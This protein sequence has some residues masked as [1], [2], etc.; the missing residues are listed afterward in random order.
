MISNRFKA[1]TQM[2][3]DQLVESLKRQDLSQNEMAEILA[4]FSHHDEIRQIS[5]EPYM[6]H[7][8]Y[9]RDGDKHYSDIRYS[10]NQRIL[11]L[12]HDTIES[13]KQDALT[14]AD[15]RYLKFDNEIVT[16]LDSITK[17]EGERYL[18][19]I[20]RLSRNEFVRPV[21]IVD[22]RH[23]MKNG[24]SPNRALLYRL[25]LPYLIAVEQ[26]AIA[27]G[28]DITKFADEIGQY[29]KDLFQTYSSRVGFNSIKLLSFNFKRS[30]GQMGMQPIIS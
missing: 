16:G 13:E 28:S 6:T 5:G 15:I 10:E 12:L 22:T 19:Y 20:E 14:L 8:Y 30:E 17:R 21:K 26:G 2:T 18:D 23:N 29:N 9:V 25:S 1:A 7:V 11:S 3:K 27:P 4:H 24:P